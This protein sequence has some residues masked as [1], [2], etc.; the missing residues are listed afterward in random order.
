MI[1]LSKIKAQRGQHLH[2]VTGYLSPASFQELRLDGLAC[3]SRSDTFTIEKLELESIKIKT[4]TAIDIE[5]FVDG[6]ELDPNFDEK[7]YFVGHHLHT[8]IMNSF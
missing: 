3:L 2:I 1:A 5:Q 7:S 6:N 8:T 4:T